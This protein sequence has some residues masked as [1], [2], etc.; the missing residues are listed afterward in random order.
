MEGDI[1][2]RLKRYTNYLRHEIEVQNTLSEKYSD[3]M[4]SIRAQGRSAALEEAVNMLQNIFPEF[5]SL[6]LI[7]SKKSAKPKH[8]TSILARE[9]WSTSEEAEAGDYR[10]GD[11]PPL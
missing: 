1:E 9:D 5:K 7:Q 6:Q 2:H 3:A 8:H 10:F 11:R 4:K